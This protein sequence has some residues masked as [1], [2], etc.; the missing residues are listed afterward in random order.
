M[1]KGKVYFTYTHTH[2]T[3]LLFYH[4]KVFFFPNTMAL[5]PLKTYIILKIKIEK[6]ICILAKENHKGTADKY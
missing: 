6:K 3:S 4:M 2:Y 5:F 1:N